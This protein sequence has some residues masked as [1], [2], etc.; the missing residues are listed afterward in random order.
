MTWNQSLS[1]WFGLIQFIN[2]TGPK[3]LWLK[4]LKTRG[5]V[6][7]LFWKTKSVLLSHP[8]IHLWCPGHLCYPILHNKCNSYVCFLLLFHSCFNIQVPGRPVACVLQSD[9]REEPVSRHEMVPALLW[10]VQGLLCAENATKELTSV[11]LAGSQLFAILLFISTQRC[12]HTG[13]YT[14]THM[15]AFSDQILW[16]HII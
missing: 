14:Y 15:H 12:T 13:A 16:L 6:V 11:R 9:T 8:R 7:I 5:F 2:R 3:I 4:I 1:V 10:D